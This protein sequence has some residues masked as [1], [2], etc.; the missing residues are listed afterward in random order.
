MNQRSIKTKLLLIEDEE[1]IRKV[2]EIYLKNENFDN[3]PPVPTHT[4]A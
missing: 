3:S 1:K 4:N 2:L